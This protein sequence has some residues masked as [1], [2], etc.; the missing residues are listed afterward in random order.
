[1]VGALWLACKFLGEES[2]GTWER[3]ESGKLFGVAL[4]PVWDQRG[5]RGHLLG[6][7]PQHG[8][9]WVEAVRSQPASA[10]PSARL[11][12]SVAAMSA[13]LCGQLGSRAWPPNEVLPTWMCCTHVPPCFWGSQGLGFITDL[14]N[15]VPGRGTCGIR[16]EGSHRFDED[17][18]LSQG[19][20]EEQPTGRR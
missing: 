6:W 17:A 15:L 9:P 1:M 4:G 3:T 2:A 10:Q 14:A 12:P 20:P 11:A 19:S 7:A 8:C 5:G 18:C 13:R 16:G